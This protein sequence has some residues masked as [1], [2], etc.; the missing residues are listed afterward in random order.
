MATVICCVSTS[1]VQLARGMRA[2]HFSGLAKDGQVTS[3]TRSNDLTTAETV[4][5]P[6]TEVTGNIIQ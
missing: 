3:P 4:M 1:R 2:K 5:A 6:I